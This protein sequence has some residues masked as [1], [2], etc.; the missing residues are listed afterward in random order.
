MSIAERKQREKQYR[1]ESIKKSARRVFAKKGFAN[2]TMS[3]IAEKAELAKG[4]LYLF[5]KSK[6]ELYYSLLEPMLENHYQ[7]ISE[8]TSNDNEP[9]DKTLARLKKFFIKTYL[10]DPAPYQVF[11]FYKADETQA[12][13]SETR[14]EHLKDL[15]RKNLHEL[16]HVIAKG[17]RQGIFKPVNPKVVS[18]AIWNLVLGILQFEQNRTFGRGKNHLKSNLDT[19]FSIVLNGLKK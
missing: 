13:F 10:N 11:M 8:V 7:Q 1:I 4:T 15:M 6:E 2:T 12:V 17:I 19:A 9:A 14:I 16:E 5:F 18:I 3:E